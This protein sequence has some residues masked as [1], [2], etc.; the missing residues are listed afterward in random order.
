MKRITLGFVLLG[1]IFIVGGCGQGARG[2]L[3]RAGKL[4][5]SEAPEDWERAIEEYQKV[6]DL[7][8]EAHDKTAYLHRRLADLF[9]EREMFNK[10]EEHYLAA[11]EFLPNVADLHYS[12]GITYAN[13]G[14]TEEG[15]LDKAIA[16]Y[17]KAVKLKPDFAKPYYGMGLI[18]FFKKGMKDAG[19]SN[20]Q[21]A[22]SCDSDY[23]DAYVALGRMYYETGNFR[24]AIEEYE[25]AISKY[26]RKA[27]IVATYYDNIG[28][29]YLALGE[30]QKAISSFEQALKINPQ[31][32]EARAHLQEM[33]IDVKDRWKK[34]E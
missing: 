34:W 28:L 18:Y 32:T 4:A 24:G 7:K 21:K 17:E 19:I 3:N 31:H 15:Y 30:N 12:L 27:K 1:L 2:Y 29:A 11:I 10:A 6:I 16:E 25:E 9:L 14:I 13:L 8:I 26:P 20:I 23:I 22:I 33:G 5:E